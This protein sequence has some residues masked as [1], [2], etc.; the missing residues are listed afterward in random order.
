M[1]NN[2]VCVVHFSKTF[3]VKN[4]NTKIDIVMETVYL[5]FVLINTKLFFLFVTEKVKETKSALAV[6]FHFK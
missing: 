3:M 2:T 6:V 1:P 4:K 5:P